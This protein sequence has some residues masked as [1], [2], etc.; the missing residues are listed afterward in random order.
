MSPLSPGAFLILSLLAGA[1]ETSESLRAFDCSSASRITL[2]G[3]PVEQIP[4]VCVNLGAP[5]TFVFDTPLPLGA[6]VLS[7]SHST[8][9]AQGGAL[10]TVYPKRNFLPGERVKLTVRF[11]DGAAP[12]EVAFWLVGRSG[13]GARSVEMFRHT[14]SVDALQKEAA[15]A[16]AKASQCQEE[17]A[18]LLADRKKPA[19]LMGVAWLERIGEIH[20]KNITKD[21]EQDSA[22][23]LTI[24]ATMSY[25]HQGALAVRL[26]ISNLTPEPWMA[27]RATLLDPT[28]TEVELSSWQMAAIQP[29]ALGI[30]V[31]GT[32]QHP[33]QVKCPCDLR[34]WA[35]QGLYDVRVGALTFPVIEQNTMPH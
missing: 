2:T 16:R 10:A 15:E 3:V 21:L 4:D 31:V 26:K 32:D 13:K 8:D 14:R 12:E 29:G 19:G 5:T 6:V 28:G 24:K 17:N 30:V 18:L 7:D 22:S 35:T 23:L 34:L 25:S 20:S 33:G 11:G 1:A 27:T 9:L